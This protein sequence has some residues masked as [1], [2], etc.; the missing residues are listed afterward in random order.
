MSEE[1]E[2]KLLINELWAVLAPLSPTASQR[3]KEL[4]ALKRHL[5]AKNSH[6]WE[7]SIEHL[8]HEVYGNAA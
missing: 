8:R 1:E 7:C 5:L 2:R 6:W 3:E 4:N